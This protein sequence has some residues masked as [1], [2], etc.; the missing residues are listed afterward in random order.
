VRRGALGLCTAVLAIGA[1]CLSAAPA[2][3]NHP[4]PGP[5]PGGHP[6]DAYNL[7][8]TSRTMAPVAVTRTTG[9]VA[10]SDALLCT[11]VIIPVL[12]ALPGFPALGSG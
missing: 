9:S 1:L 3:A 12:S 2:L 11:L 10:G 5:P 6:W 7:S 8:P 4:D